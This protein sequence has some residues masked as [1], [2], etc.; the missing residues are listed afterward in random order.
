MDGQGGVRTAPPLPPQDRQDQDV[1]AEKIED[2]QKA[3]RNEKYLVLV[4]LFRNRLAF[5]AGTR[6]WDKETDAAVDLLVGTQSNLGGAFLSKLTIDQVY[7][8]GG[9]Y[10]QLLKPDYVQKHIIA[11]QDYDRLVSAFKMADKG[12]SAAYETF[13]KGLLPRWAYPHAAFFDSAAVDRIREAAESL[14][15]AQLPVSFSIGGV[16]GKCL[17]RVWVRPDCGQQLGLLNA[18]RRGDLENERKQKRQRICALGALSPKS[19]G[20]YIGEKGGMLPQ[21]TGMTLINPAEFQREVIIV[22]A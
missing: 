6:A 15:P 14:I 9:A 11:P 16:G 13:S 17:D 4:E 10:L 22:L 21:L 7:S 19:K 8:H 18:V 2:N 20:T 12:L 3:L 1:R 5:L